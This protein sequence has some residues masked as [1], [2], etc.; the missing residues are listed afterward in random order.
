[1][2]DTCDTVFRVSS[3]IIMKR[4]VIHV[5]HYTNT[6]HFRGSLDRKA[7]VMKTA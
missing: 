2:S 1:M 5:K 4:R 3:M 7:S 6:K